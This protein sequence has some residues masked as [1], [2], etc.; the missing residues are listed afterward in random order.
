[1]VTANLALYKVLDLNQKK[2]VPMEAAQIPEF[3]SSELDPDDERSQEFASV[4]YI[5][6]ELNIL[7]AYSASIL[8]NVSTD[9]PIA[10]GFGESRV[11]VAEIHKLSHFPPILL[12]IRLPDGYPTEKPPQMELESEWFPR[13][14]KL[15]LEAEIYRRWRDTHDYV[16]Y[17]T[18][19]ILQ[20]EAKQG[21]GLLDQEKEQD[22]ALLLQRDLEERFVAFNKKTIKDIFNRGTYSC[23]VCLGM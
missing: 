23:G 21:F 7:D 2:A 22:I 18:I 16:L 19:D 3:D 12:K 6:P 11:E 13:I 9:S 20:Q 17:D 5:F 14:V 8:I 10:V 15:K 4:P 1:M